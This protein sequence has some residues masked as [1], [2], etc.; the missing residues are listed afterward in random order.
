MVSNGRL[1]RIVVAVILDRGQEQ[2]EA[3]HGEFRC[4]RSES[5]PA[6]SYVAQDTPLRNVHRTVTAK[7]DNPLP[8]CPIR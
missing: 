4:T 7:R 3:E 1:E 5:S 6:Q 8:G 2:R